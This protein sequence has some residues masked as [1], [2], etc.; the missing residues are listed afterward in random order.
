MKKHE[1]RIAVLDIETSPILAYVWS[2]W[3]QNVGLNQI[4]TDWS[5]L[6]FSY[7]WLGEK[8]VI[9]HSTGGR[10]PSKVRDD[11]GLM[12]LLWKVLDEADI[13]VAQNGVA[14]DVKKINARFIEL[15]M[16]PPA[17]FKVVDTMLEARRIARFSSNRL[18]WLSEILT[19]TPKS[20]HKRFPG[21][22]LWTECLAD[23]PEAWKEMRKY[24]DIDI[25]ATEKVYL[26]LRP[27]IIGHPNVAAY[28]D[29]TDVRCPKCGSAVMQSRGV[30]LTQ[31]GEYKRYQ[32]KSCGG[33]AR[34][35]YTQNS[36]GKRR[37][38]LSN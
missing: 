20:E 28:D 34:G 12:K 35:R 25:R 23:N 11:G 8:R 3:K 37:S 17:P 16:P 19:D 13:I 4:H 5:I 36:I 21:F 32:C 26:R 15:E 31:S 1:A 38:L 7:K 29:S 10:G 9:H 14:F 6:S 22:E 18:A 27:Y 33:W 24:N 2:L 30:A